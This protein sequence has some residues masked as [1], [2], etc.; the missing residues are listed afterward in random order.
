MFEATKQFSCSGLAC[1]NF[2]VSMKGFVLQ[3]E[4]MWRD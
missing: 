1:H 2:E 3:K 4:D